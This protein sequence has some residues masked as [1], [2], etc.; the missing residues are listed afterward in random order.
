MYPGNDKPK[1]MKFFKKK[2][3]KKIILVI[4]GTLLSLLIYTKITEAP[5]H[6]PSDY[7]TIRGVWLTHV[8]NSFYAVTGQLDNVFH[9][10]SRL[11]FNTVYLSV[12]NDGVTY[13]SKIIHRNQ[14]SY[15]PWINTLNTAIH[16]AKKQGLKIYGWFEYGLMLNSN[17]PIAKQHPDWLLGEGKLVNGFVWLNPSH[18]K[19]QE[20][21]INLFTEFAYLYH[22]LDGIQ[23]DDHWSIP[24]EFGNYVNELTQLTA[25]IAYKIKTINPDWV[26]S[27]SP[28]HLSFAFDAPRPKGLGFLIHRENLL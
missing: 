20:Y 15:I 25:K 16:Q 19:G 13:Q 18:P 2:R 21:F 23:L 17:D 7:Q 4:I 26:I 22:K 3:I 9:Q 6:Q 27:L 10:L 5:A 11:N 12:Y 28:N 8:G 1:T 24:A 14:E